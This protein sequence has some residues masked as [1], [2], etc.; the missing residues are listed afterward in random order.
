MAANHPYLQDGT[1]QERLLVRLAENEMDATRDPSNI[2]F[3][4]ENLEE[5]RR[6]LDQFVNHDLRELGL[7]LLGSLEARC[8]RLLSVL[9][10]FK[11]AEALEGTLAAGA[12]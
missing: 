3:V 1:V 5:S 2:A 11:E 12:H 8:H 6:F 9:R 4:P 7:P 10:A